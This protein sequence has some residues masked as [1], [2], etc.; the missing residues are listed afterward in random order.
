MVKRKIKTNSVFADTI[1]QNITD[2]LSVTKNR[3]YFV[4]FVNLKAPQTH[5]MPQEV[6]SKQIT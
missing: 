3:S 5:S 1:T 6:K 4:N 2:H